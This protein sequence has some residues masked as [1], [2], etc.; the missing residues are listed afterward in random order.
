MQ[1]NKR[2]AQE[3]LKKGVGLTRALPKDINKIIFVSFFCFTVPEHL[4]LTNDCQSDSGLNP[5]FR[6]NTCTHALIGKYHSS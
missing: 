5:I 2:K 3:P 4:I 1:I 6:T